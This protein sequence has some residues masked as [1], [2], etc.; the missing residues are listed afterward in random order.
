M[1]TNYMTIL[2][3]KAS[4][5]AVEYTMAFDASARPYT[6]VHKN[7]SNVI[8]PGYLVEAGKYYEVVCLQDKEGGWYWIAAIEHTR[9]SI[10]A[11]NHS[12]RPADTGMAMAV[13]G[14]SKP[15]AK[16]TKRSE[17]KSLADEAFIWN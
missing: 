14:W 10:R 9:E 12:A 5:R 3:T 11:L 13:R 17:P 2:V 15:Q 1:K 4:A 6:Y 16:A 8:N 7:T